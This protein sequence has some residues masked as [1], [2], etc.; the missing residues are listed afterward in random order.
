MEWLGQLL[1]DLSQSDGWSGWK[2]ILVSSF[3]GGIVGLGKIL[4]SNRHV[5][6]RNKAESENNDSGQEENM[7]ENK[8]IEQGTSLA[9]SIKAIEDLFVKARYDQAY[10][11][12]QELCNDY[13]DYQ[14]QAAMFSARYRS[15]EDQGFAGILSSQEKRIEN[16][17]IAESFQGCLQRFK[18]EF[19]T[20][21]K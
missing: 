19:L 9:E 2:V 8:R 3:F 13:P 10:T 5:N 1:Q 21:K 20:E 4:Y 15:Y 14:S 17:K 18:Q 11:K 16:M 7:I 6:R 12:F